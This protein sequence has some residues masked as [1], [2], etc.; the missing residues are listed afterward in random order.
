MKNK[1]KDRVQLLN[2]RLGRYVKIDT[3]NGGIVGHKKSKGPYKN[4]KHY[5]RKKK[6]SEKE[7]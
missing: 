3:K 7:D 2:P 5:R 1:I 6:E 4:V